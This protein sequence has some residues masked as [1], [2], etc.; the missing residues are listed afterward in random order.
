MAEDLSTTVASDSTGF[1]RSCGQKK[2]DE[3]IVYYV[4]YGNEF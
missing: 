1:Y 4:D 3:L 2:S